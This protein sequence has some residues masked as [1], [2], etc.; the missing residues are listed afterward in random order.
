LLILG[1][2]CNT[3]EQFYVLCIN[4]PTILTNDQEV[5]AARAP[6]ISPATKCQFPHVLSSHKN[7]KIIESGS[8]QSQ[9]W[10]PQDPIGMGI[11]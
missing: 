11:L 3:R 7:R 2:S 4:K 8:R 9:K 1:A 5:T 10:G 6:G